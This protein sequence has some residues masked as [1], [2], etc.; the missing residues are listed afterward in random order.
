MRKAIYGVGLA[1]LGFWAAMGA[2]AQEKKQEEPKP[3]AAGAAQAPPTTEAA[4]AEPLPRP[5]RPLRAEQFQRLSPPDEKMF[6]NLKALSPDHDVWIDTERKRVLLRGGVCLREGPVELFACIHQWVDDAAAPGGKSRRGT[7]EYESIV[8]INTTA[9]LIHTAL[10]AVGAEAG[11]PVQFAPQ[12]RPASGSEI[13]VTLYWEGN[14]DGVPAQQWLRNTKTKEAMTHPWVF[15]GSSFFEDDR[16]GQRR[17]LGEGGNL[18]CVSNFIDAVLD[19]PVPSTAANDALLFE[20]FTENIPPLGAPVTIV[21][22]PKK[23][24]P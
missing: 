9:K 12:Y 13:E 8:T 16:T 10:L 4:P 14:R 11:E 3:S 17:Y 23:A 19:I 15:A 7:K 5:K 21:L 24:K 2:S 6:P 20:A 18:I 1:A 22:T